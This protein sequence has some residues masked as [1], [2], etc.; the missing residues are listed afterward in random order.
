VLNYLLEAIAKLDATNRV[1]VGR[2]AKQ[3]G[4]L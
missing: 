4:C 2:I 3:K 1:D